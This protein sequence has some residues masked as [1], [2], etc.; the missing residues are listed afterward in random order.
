MKK[1][2][3]RK[4]DREI[5]RLRNQVVK[6]SHLEPKDIESRKIVKKILKKSKSWMKNYT[7]KI[8]TEK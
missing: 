1:E 2:E 3:M 6:I 4:L 5:I 8:V 7:T